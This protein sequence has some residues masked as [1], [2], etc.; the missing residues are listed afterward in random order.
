MK[1]YWKI[2]LLYPEGIWWPT[3]VK[4]HEKKN[5]FTLI[6]HFGV[7]TLFSLEYSN[8]HKVH[9]VYTW[10]TTV[11]VPSSELPEL[12]PPPLSRKLVCL[13]TKRGGLTR[14]RVGSQFGRLEKKP[15]YSVFSVI[16][17]HGVTLGRIVNRSIEN[18]TLRG[19]VSISRCT[20]D[21]KKFSTSI[22]QIS[23]KTPGRFF[24]IN[25]TLIHS[26]RQQRPQR[27]E[28]ARYW[29]DLR[30]EYHPLSS[31]LQRW[32]LKEVLRREIQGLKV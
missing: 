19:M 24:C 18:K 3:C 20:H 29:Y 9:T 32:S 7:Y 22:T 6:K 10:S 31:F 16:I 4:T 12:G 13:G 28:S 2:F 23:V 17:T 25:P 8:S 14:L 11:S 27:C 1:N 26:S 30:T 5:I 21:G 15:V